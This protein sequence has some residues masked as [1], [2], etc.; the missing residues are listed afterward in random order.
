MDILRCNPDF[1]RRPRYD[2]VI[3]QTVSG[4][5][6]GQLIFI[7]ECTLDKT[8]YTFALIHPFDAPIGPRRQKDIDLGFYRL[9]EKPRKSAEFIP[10]RSIVRGALTVDDFAQDGY[11]LVVDLVDTDMFLRLKSIY[12]M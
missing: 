9:R 3:V 7:F 12:P 4:F 1:Y 2:C 11:R 6:F 8:T 5:I 10:V